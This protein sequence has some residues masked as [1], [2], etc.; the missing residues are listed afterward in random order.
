[1][2]GLYEEV[3]YLVKNL[4]PCLGESTACVHEL[5]ASHIHCQI[6]VLTHLQAKMYVQ[7]ELHWS[8]MSCHILI[9]N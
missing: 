8:F 4:C 2:K 1:M 6:Q 3:I 5:I 7:F 9:I